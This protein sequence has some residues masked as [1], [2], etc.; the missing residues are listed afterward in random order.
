MSAG[1]G[2]QRGEQTDL[3]SRGVIGP[4]RSGRRAPTYITFF[5]FSHIIAD[6]RAKKR[7]PPPTRRPWGSL[8]LRIYYVY[9]EGITNHLPVAMFRPENF[10]DNLSMCVLISRYASIY[11]P[12]P[13]ASRIF[14]DIAREYFI[15]TI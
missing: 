13:S 9:N 11:S 5:P 4:N 10:V 12:Y 2:P 14:H 3:A 8:T 1:P 15:S 6:L 7:L